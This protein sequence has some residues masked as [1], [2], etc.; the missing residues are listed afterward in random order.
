MPSALSDLKKF[1]S[2]PE[3]GAYLNCAAHGP[4]SKPASEAVIRAVRDKENPTIMDQNYGNSRVERCRAA[5]SKLVNCHPDQVALAN[6]TSWGVNVIARGFKWKSGDE[7]VAFEGQFPS[8]IA[9]WEP[10]KNR[11]VTLKKI[12]APN[13]ICDIDAFKKSLTSKTRIA[14]LE[15]VHFVSG[16]RIPLEEI[17]KICHERGIF[18]VVDVTQG[19]GAIPFS[20]KATGVDAVVCSSYKW[21]Y[22]PYGSGFMALS[23]ELM[24]QI[25]TTDI[26][27]LSLETNWTDNLCDYEVAFAANAKRFDV[28]AQMG[29]MNLDG[30]TASI[31]WI[32]T[33]D[34]K[35]NFKNVLE[36]TRQLREELS[37]K[38]FTPMNRGPAERQSCIATFYCPDVD[39]E[40]LI[41]ALQIEGYSTCIRSKGLRVAP[42]IYNDERQIA[43]FTKL[44]NSTVSK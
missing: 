36:L 13:Y 22:S 14:S 27:W 1:F 10:L 11:G 6:S 33:I 16:D 34:I 4:L 12:G 3:R 23:T 32:N 29:Y 19:L 42:S 25:D 35:R 37:P 2:L 31:E 17:T 7:V 24:A 26:N 40:K 20:M 44:V 18:V 28:F 21:L 43:G 8:N 38:F 9:P 5:V 41:S 15:W 30:M 39:G